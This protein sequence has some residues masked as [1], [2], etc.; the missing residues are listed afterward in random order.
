MQV[1]HDNNDVFIIEK[2]TEMMPLYKI[3]PGN[4]KFF[5][6]GNFFISFIILSKYNQHW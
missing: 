2:N 3:F 1:R 4:L 6:N 5:C